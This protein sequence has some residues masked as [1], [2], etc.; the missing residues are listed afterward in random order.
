MAPSRC[1]TTS[2]RRSACADGAQP[3]ASLIQGTDG[4]FYGTTALG[5]ATNTGTI[6]KMT[7]SG[8]ITT[9]H[10]FNSTD[11]SEP[12]AALLQGSDGNFYGTTFRRNRRRRARSLRS[13]RREPSPRCTASAA[14]TAPIP[15]AALVQVGSG[16]F[17]GTTYMGGSDGLG[18]I[19]HLTISACLH[20]HRS[21]QHAQSLVPGCR[22]S[23]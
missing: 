1:C 13:L 11:G 19:F 6:F 7:S 5:N 20:H 3:H 17:D 18:T 22:A 4:N 23:P 8:A 12:S 21:D 2:A 9:L 10:S 15:Q 14:A 16:V